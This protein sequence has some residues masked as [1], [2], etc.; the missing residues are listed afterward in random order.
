[1]VDL[2]NF[3]LELLKDALVQC[4]PSEFA[5]M[6]GEALAHEKLLREIRRMSK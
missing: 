6:Q 3:R 1:M 4:G 2:L 5:R